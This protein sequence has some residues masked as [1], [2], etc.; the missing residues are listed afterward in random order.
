MS[1]N[2][3]FD[4]MIKNIIKDNDIEIKPS[5][6]IFEDSWNMREKER[7]ISVMKRIN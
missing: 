5:R 2:I 1:K 3:N 4:N 6:D 7:N